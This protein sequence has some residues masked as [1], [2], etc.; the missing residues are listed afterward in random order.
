MT[1][2]LI[3]APQLPHYEYTPPRKRSTDN[4][5]CT[6]VCPQ[7]GFSKHQCARI[8]MDCKAVNNR[9]PEIK[10]V[11][12][13]DGN[14]C[15]KLPATKGVYAYVD[16]HLYDYVMQW[17]WGAMRSTKEHPWYLFFK[18]TLD[19]K[20][21]LVGLHHLVM[22]VPPAFML[23]HKNGNTLDNRAR[24]LR[25]CTL[26]NNGFNRKKHRNNTSGYMGVCW[27]RQ[28][29][30]W[31]G[32]VTYQNKRYY[33]GRH[34]TDKAYVAW[35]RD[36]LAAKLFGEFATFNFPEK[37]NAWILEMAQSGHQVISSTQGHPCA[38]R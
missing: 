4:S 10:E 29:K 19:G 15:R 6:N 1:N 8:C 26:Q 21:Q 28:S 20:K 7:C 12:F 36:M 5:R 9:P 30:A 24:N 32:S 11:F 17:R 14:P 23:D 31:R 33:V 22:G 25:P 16:A 35:L 27:H 37:A 2:L 13:I 38:I 3:Q 34:S 18:L